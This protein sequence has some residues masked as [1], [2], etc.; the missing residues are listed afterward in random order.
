MP[1]TNPRR[2]Q[3]LTFASDVF[4]D[5]EL[6]AQ[7]CAQMGY[8]LDTRTLRAGYFAFR[9]TDEGYLAQI[10][11]DTN[12]WKF[13]GRFIQ[14]LKTAYNTRL[15]ESYAKKVKA[16][17]KVTQTKQGTQIRVSFNRSVR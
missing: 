9:K 10:A 13:G 2:S 12:D 4:K 6:L 7:A 15:A 8:T 1:C 5:L 14:K 16:V 3:T 11:E 17:P